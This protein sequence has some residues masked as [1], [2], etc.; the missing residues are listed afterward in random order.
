M[1]LYDFELSGGCYKI[2][3][4]LNILGLE[5]EKLD[6]DFLGRRQHTTQPHLALSPF[7]EIPIL[8]DDGFRLHDAQ[9]ILVYLASKYDPSGRWYPEDAEG[10]GLI[11]QWLSA[12]SSEIMN[13]AGA[14][15][16]RMLNYPLDLAAL[17]AGAERVFEIMDTHLASHD[18]L[19]V[20][21]PTIADIACFPDTAMAGEG[22][23]DL[24]PYPH[25]VQWIERMNGIDGFIPTPD[26]PPLL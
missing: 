16:V 17:Q 6:V 7:G 9:A 4:F 19:A 14:R 2:R 11:Q 18:W 1:K 15:L 8:E 22:G 13:A 25:L 3:L 23:I 20:G 10:A 24:E 12:A 5:Y 26:N 21:H